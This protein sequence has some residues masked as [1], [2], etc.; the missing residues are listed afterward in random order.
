MTAAK[1][2][3]HVIGT[4]GS[5]AGIGPD[6]LDYILYP[7]IGDHLTIEQSLERVPEINDLA[8]IT[9]EDLVSVGS[10]A[11]GP[12]DWLALTRRINGLMRED[13]GLTGIAVTHGTATL[14]ETAYFLHLAVKTDKPVVITGAMRPP[15]SIGTDA[16]AN[17]MDAVRIAATPHAGGMGVLTVLNNEIHSARDV[18]KSNTFRVETFRPNELGFLGYSDSDGQVVF[19]RAPVRKHTTGTAFDIEGRDSM[20]RVEI[21]YSYAGADGAI[22]DAVRQ[23]RPDGLVVAGFGGG[24]YPPEFI[25]AAARAVE[26]GIPVVLASR[27]TAGRVVMTPRKEEQGFIVSDN[28]LPQKARILLMMALTVSNERDWLMQAFR[29]Y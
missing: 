12:A 20:P 18:S 24:T 23:M 11:I 6:R 27:S 19:Y 28:L 17:L 5:I 2:R 4:G 26:D 25:A 14:E 10:T 8:S 15:T 16:D 13:S 7:E 29:E 9:S 22:V 3:V 21:V 1:P